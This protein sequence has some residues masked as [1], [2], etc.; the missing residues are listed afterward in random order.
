MELVREAGMSGWLVVMLA[1]FGVLLGVIG[2]AMA[3]ARPR[4]AVMLATLALGLGVVSIVTGL[5]GRSSGLASTLQAVAH[6]NPADR[7]TI[8][9][10][11]RSESGSNLV[12]GGGA[13][14]VLSVLGAAGLAVAFSGAKR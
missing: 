4:D 3:R 14:L 8:L 2:L 13:G 9:A 1:L 11:G 12:L 7:A 5:W 6:V 10:A